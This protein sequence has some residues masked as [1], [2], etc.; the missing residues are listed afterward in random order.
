MAQK[1]LRVIGLKVKNLMGVKAIEIEPGSLPVVKIGGDNGAGKSSL[2][3]SLFLPFERSSNKLVVI[4]QG[5]DSGEVEIDFGDLTVRKIWTKDK[6]GRE[7]GELIVKNAAGAPYEKGLDLLQ[8]LINKV[9]VDP[10]AIFAM[11]PKERRKEFCR[12]LGIDADILEAEVALWSEKRKEAKKEETRLAARFQGMPNYPDAP[13]ELVSAKDV[14]D[15]L[16]EAQRHN[17]QKTVL[18][19]QVASKQTTLENGLARIKDKE[20]EV[21]DLRAKLATA[22]AKL[23]EWRAAADLI[24]SEIQELS[25]SVLQFKTVDTGPIERELGTIEDVNNQVRANAE[26]IKGRIEFKAAENVRVEAEKHLEAL[27]QK[28]RDAINTGLSN[29]KLHFPNVELREDDIY[30][31]GLPITQINTAKRI[32]MAIDLASVNAP[33]LRVIRCPDAEKMTRPMLRLL[34]A[35]ARD[36]GYQVWAELAADAD[37]IAAGFRIV[38]Y[39]L[40]DGELAPVPK[41]EK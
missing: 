22:V 11:D 24:E 29:A 20:A 31:D 6:E 4:R 39:Y 10:F 23:D 37:D 2:I 34:E 28:K 12:M 15:R 3:N 16:A 41:Q 21:D 26:K 8:R 5:E 27:E 18:E 7:R 35:I 17:T 36:R 33:A 1:S 25:K 40:E 32:N 19:S 13:K 38:D 14:S 9:A 30:V